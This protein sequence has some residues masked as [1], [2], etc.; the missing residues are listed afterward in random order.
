M[1]LRQNCPIMERLFVRLPGDP[2]HAPG[3]TVPAGTLREGALPAHLRALLAPPVF[4]EEEIPEGT[5]IVEH[6]LPDGVARLIVH[7]QG[8]PS[9]EVAGP[10]AEPV[11]LRQQGHSRGFSIA[12]QPGAASVLLGA[13]PHELVGRC[14][15]L[16][17]LWGAAAAELGEQLV[18]AK[19]DAARAAVLFASLAQR[20]VAAPHKSTDRAVAV[21][22]AAHIARAG[23]RCTV[24]SLSRWTGVGERRLQ[25]S[26]REHLGLGP[27]TWI[28]LARM[29][30]CIRLLRAGPVRWAHLA[31][32]A[33]F[34]DQAH[35]SNEFR[36]L[37]GLTPSRFLAI[38]GF[39]KTSSSASGTLP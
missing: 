32:D 35:L 27:R 18:E 21:H 38:S 1:R 17:D 7:L 8:D 12:L 11:T 36:A 2:V 37:C 39:S 6:V 28:R 15:K 4:Y 29:Q 26:F 10:S 31:A 16:D 3:T 13:S 33:G 19:D 25:Q 23:G 30:E 14:V 9:I 5:E 24:A 34:A 22:A 20:A